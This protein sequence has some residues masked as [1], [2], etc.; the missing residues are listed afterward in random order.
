MLDD[1]RR[2]F[3]QPVTVTSAHRCR[4]S[5]AEAGGVKHSLHLLGRAADIQ[6]KNTA[7]S[8]VYEFLD[9]RYIKTGGLGNYTTFT[10]VDSRQDKARWDMRQE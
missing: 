8:D 9:G 5:N 7:P 10:H 2:A 1:V 6:V 4:E 3:G